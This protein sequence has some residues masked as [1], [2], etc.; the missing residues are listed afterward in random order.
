MRT[1]INE[2]GTVWSKLPAELKVALYIATSYGL[3]EV[4]IELGRLE[5]NNVWLAIAL[6][7]LLVFLREIKPRVERFREDN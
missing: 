4:I 5:I 7:I 6:N 2:I 1:F 3:S